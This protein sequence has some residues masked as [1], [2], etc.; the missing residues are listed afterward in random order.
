M[1]SMDLWTVLLTPVTPVFLFV[2]TEWTESWW[3]DKG[4]VRLFKVAAG[5]IEYDL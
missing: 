1:D 4:Q 5:V 3:E 2:Q